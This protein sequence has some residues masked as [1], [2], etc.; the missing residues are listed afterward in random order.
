MLSFSRIFPSTANGTLTSSVLLRVSFLVFLEVIKTQNSRR[1]AED[2][3]MWLPLPLNF[4]TDACS[5]NSFGSAV[6]ECFY[7][8]DCCLI[9]RSESCIHFQLGLP[10]QQSLAV[11]AET[12]KEQQSPLLLLVCCQVWQHPS[13][14]SC[15]HA[16]LGVDNNTYTVMRHSLNVL[17]WSC[18]M[19]SWKSHIFFCHRTF[20]TIGKAMMD[21]HPL[22]STATHLFTVV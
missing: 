3:L 15:P 13:Y 4:R 17:S 21:C 5:R 22:F 11:G 12:F 2:R 10:T 7:C 19:R 18:I 8:S 6:L 20:Q 1:V 16:Q 14:G 9:S